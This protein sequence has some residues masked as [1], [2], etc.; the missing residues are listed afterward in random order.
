MY[1]VYYILYI[2][3]IYD[4]FVI[5]YSVAD[6]IMVH[7]IYKIEADVKCRKQMKYI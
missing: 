5:I 4:G 2:F 1:N 3:I 6:Q 7:C